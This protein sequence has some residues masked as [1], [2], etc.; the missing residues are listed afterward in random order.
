M[1]HN[2][3]FPPLLRGIKSHITQPVAAWLQPKRGVKKIPS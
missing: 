2:P 3:L 1:L